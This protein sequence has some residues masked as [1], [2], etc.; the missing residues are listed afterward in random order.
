MVGELSIEEL[1]QAVAL[2]G[3]CKYGELVAQD[4]DAVVPLLM[5]ETA[6]T[7]GR[8]DKAIDGCSLDRKSVV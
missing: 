7:W 8:S 4:L 2:F 1:E 6:L 3:G 5:D